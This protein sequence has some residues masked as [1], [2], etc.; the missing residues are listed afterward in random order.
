MSNGPGAAGDAAG[1]GPEDALKEI[2]W[3]QRMTAAIGRPVSFAML[4]F[5]SRPDQWREL[6]EQ[7]QQGPVQVP[8]D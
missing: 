6:Q 3:M 8:A 1:D 7:A 5:D 2:E 4:Q